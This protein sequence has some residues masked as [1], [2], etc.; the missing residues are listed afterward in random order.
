M[1]E[2]HV[3]QIA[4]YGKG[5]IGKSTI[6]CNLSVALA[7]QGHNVM[8]IGCSP[9]SDSTAFLRGGEIMEHPVLEYSRESGM[10]EKLILDTIEK[11]YKGILCAESGGPD[12]G[13]GCAGRGVAMALEWF[14]KYD[15]YKKFGV[16]IVIYDSIADVV[17]GGFGQPMKAGYAE[18]VY[19][20]TSG[21]LM[22]T[23]STN[24]ICSAIKTVAEAGANTRACG[25]LVNLR[26]V[27]NEVAVVDDFS[28]RIGVPIMGV[29]PRSQLIQRAEAQG[30]TVTEIFPESEEAKLYR[31]LAEKVA[32]NKEKYMPSPITLEEIIELARKHQAFE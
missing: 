1:A 14:A 13:A 22:S 5:S 32:N 8:Q 7:E 21:E 6:A 18:E 30:G 23:Y 15:I 3:R 27:E 12:P 11:G 29:I 25:L 31:E 2:K 19:L 28:K 9:K 16:D 17:C 20:V 26:G 4:I 10:D 24:N